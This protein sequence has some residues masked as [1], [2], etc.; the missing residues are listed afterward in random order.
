MISEKK[1]RPAC[2]KYTKKL[3]HEDLGGGVEQWIALQR[4]MHR[5]LVEAKILHRSPSKMH[6]NGMTNQSE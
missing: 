1:D 6:A 4:L 2:K 5:L 3:N